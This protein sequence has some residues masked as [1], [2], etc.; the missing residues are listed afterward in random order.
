MLR[1]LVIVLM[2]A[3]LAPAQYRRGRAL[4]SPVEKVAAI[5]DGKV[6]TISKK[7]ISIERDDENVMVF[8]IGRKTKFQRDGKDADWKSFHAGDQ[9]TIQADEDYPG[10]FAALAIAPAATAKP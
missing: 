10:H 3:S 7:E 4:P 9:V 1:L 2:A 6:H 5:I 8:S